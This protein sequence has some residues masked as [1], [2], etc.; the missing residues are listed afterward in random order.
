MSAP[1]R[2][3]LVVEQPGELARTQ[4]QM[5]QVHLIDAVDYSIG[6]RAAG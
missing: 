1:D 3:A 5:L 6:E 4:E 2:P